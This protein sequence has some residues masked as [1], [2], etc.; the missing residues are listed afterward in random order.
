MLEK[1]EPIENSNIRL[2]RELPEIAFTYDDKRDSVKKSMLYV[3]ILPGS[4]KSVKLPN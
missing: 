3:I 1:R 2:V 4:V